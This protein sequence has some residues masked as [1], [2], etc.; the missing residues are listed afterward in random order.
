MTSEETIIEQALEILAA[1]LK[2]ISDVLSSPQTVRKYLIVKLAQ[3]E[4]EIFGAVW[5]NVRN[6]VIAYEDIAFG[7]L[8]HASVYPREVVKSALKHNAASVIF[9]HNHPSGST[10]PSRADEALTAA[11]KSALALVDVSV[12]DHFIVAGTEIM[13]F[14]ERGQI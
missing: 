3:E 13:S 8:A 11:L 10:E 14:A 2:Q 5:L 4:R 6:G 9:V 1:R 7:T 12:L